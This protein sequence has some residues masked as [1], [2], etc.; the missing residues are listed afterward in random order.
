METKNSKRQWLFPLLL[1]LAT[2]AIIAAILLL[3]GAPQ[4]EAHDSVSDTQTVTEA[5]TEP[6]SAA[7]AHAATETQLPP[8][9]YASHMAYMHGFD[10]FFNPERPLTRAEAAILI[11]RL[12]GGDEDPSVYFYDVSEDSSVYHEI[13][14]VCDRFPGSQYA[15]FRPD[16]PI[17]REELFTALCS[18]EELPE[19]LMN[20]EAP[21]TAFARQ[22]GWF[23]PAE[24]SDQVLRGEAAH[25]FNCVLGRSPDRSLLM[26]KSPIVFADVSPACP[27]YADIMEAAVAHEYPEGEDAEHWRVTDFGALKSGI[28]IQNGAA[29]CLI[30]D[31]TLLTQPGIHDTQFGTVCVFDDSGLIRADDRPHLTPDGVIFCCSDGTVLKNAERN[32]YFFDENGCYS[33]G[34]SELDDFVQAV[35]DDCTT[36][37]MTQEEKLRACYDYVRNF[38]YLGRNQPLDYTVKTMPYDLARGYALKIFKT[39]KGDCYNFTAAFL[40]L[41]RGLGYDAEGIIGYCSYFWSRSAI[42]HGWVEITMDDGTVYLFDPQLENYNDRAGISNEYYGA[43]MTTYA[44]SYATYY[45]N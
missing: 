38:S 12:F 13:I 7:E 20:E 34:D 37:K 36:E 43:Y 8:P 5:S 22:N 29:Y 6:S 11:Y 24:T 16:D 39:G 31:G 1:V 18:A 10:S 4:T 42:A 45:P 30:D 28:Y 44:A 23:E 33:S 3:R 40:F 21:Y 9:D 27:Y 19:D 2:A 35:Y 17:T 25:I 41:A 32:G 14:S 26:Q 15:Y